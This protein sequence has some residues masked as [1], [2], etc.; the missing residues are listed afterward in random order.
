MTTARN[1]E[2]QTFSRRRT[3]NL[4]KF[5][6]GAR[7]QQLANAGA[8]ELRMDV[9]DPNLSLRFGKNA[10][11]KSEKRCCAYEFAPRQHV[12]A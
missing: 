9:I 6:S 4:R 10:R 7:L 2:W 11:R 8:I 3:H 5:L 1:G 12:E